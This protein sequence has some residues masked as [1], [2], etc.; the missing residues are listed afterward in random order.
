[1][2]KPSTASR[3]PS[4]ISPDVAPQA[5]LNRRRLHA[6]RLDRCQNARLTLLQLC[7]VRLD[8]AHALLQEQWR[9]VTARPYERRTQPVDMGARHLVL[10][11][12]GLLVLLAGLRL[13]P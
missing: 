2:G 13:A 6:C 7:E 10:P 3:S 1:M 12:G 11:V 9:K 4:T 5:Q 8:L